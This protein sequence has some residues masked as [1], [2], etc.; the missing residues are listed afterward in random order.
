MT[1]VGVTDNPILP[2]SSGLP[3]YDKDYNGGKD[4]LILKLDNIG[5][6]IVY[7]SFFGGSGDESKVAD[8]EFGNQAYF[9]DD[10]LKIDFLDSKIYLIGRTNSSDIP[11]VNSIDNIAGQ[12][13]AFVLDASLGSSNLEFASYFKYS[14]GG[15]T[16]FKDG[17]FAIIAENIDGSY[18]NMISPNAIESEVKVIHLCLYFLYSIV[19]IH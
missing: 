12:G 5:Q 6:N 2:G 4:I 11:I 1:L 18:D 3:G 9:W 14:G 19:Q 15:I 8:F 16:S 10:K 17:K 13:F 7:S